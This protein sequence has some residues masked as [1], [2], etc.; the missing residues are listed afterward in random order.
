MK[1]SSTLINPGI[2][3]IRSIPKKGRGAFAKIDIPKGTVIEIA[4]VIPMTLQEAQTISKTVVHFYTFEWH[5]KDQETGVEYDSA[6]ISG[7]GQML[8][9]SEKPNAEFIWDYPNRNIIMKSLKNIKAGEEITHDYG[10][11]LWFNPE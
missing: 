5:E 2:I 4:P 9:H 3:E 7:Y 11:D 6:I 1:N 8:N 10:C